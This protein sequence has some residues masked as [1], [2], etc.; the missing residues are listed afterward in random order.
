MDECDDVR[1]Y[2]PES[3]CVSNCENSATAIRCDSRRCPCGVCDDA[4]LHELQEQ[5][6][7]MVNVGDGR[8]HGIRAIDDTNVYG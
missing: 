2:Q 7:E 8:G 4:A 1:N 3:W 6:I 5:R